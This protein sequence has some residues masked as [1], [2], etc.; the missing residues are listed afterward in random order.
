MKIAVHADSAFSMLY[1]NRFLK[2]EQWEVLGL[3]YNSN[4]Q[5]YSE[6]HRQLL[7]QKLVGVLE[8]IIMLYPE[9]DLEGYLKGI[10]AFST[11][12]ERCDFCYRHILEYTAR[13]AQQLEMPYFTTSLLLHPKH[14]QVLLKKIG[15]ELA[16]KYQLK[17]F[18]QDL[19]AHW[20][21]VADLASKLN[22]YQPPYCG[23]LY[24]ERY[25]FY[26]ATI[27]AAASG[28]GTNKKPASRVTTKK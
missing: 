25:R 4:I 17:F 9:Y 21:D 11:Q 20:N 5:P 13:Y 6:Y 8:D 22:V 16:E 10:S 28:D 1:F 7:M 2:K 27:H 15:D 23:C 14:D 19:T 3:Y 18:H 24:S 26:P 12:E